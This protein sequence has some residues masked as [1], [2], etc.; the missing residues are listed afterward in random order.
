MAGD[1]DLRTLD[2]SG[3]C[4]T[5]KALQP[6][7]IIVSTA[8]GAESWIVRQGSAS[9]VSQVSHASLYIGAGHV[10]AANSNGVVTKTLDA[11]FADATL[12]VALRHRN[13]TPGAA[14]GVICFAAANLGKKYDYTG[15]I[16]AGLANN[17]RIYIFGLLG[18]LAS[19]AARHRLFSSGNKFYCSEIVL[20]AYLR[21]GVPITDGPTDTSTPENIVEAYLS[22][23]IDYVGHL[24]DPVSDPPAKYENS[25]YFKGHVMRPL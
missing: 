22:Q 4:I 1:I 14:C 25:Y 9:H 8:T 20:D 24:V 12:A 17:K 5:E 10:I 6:A 15:A 19:L 3:R 18:Y 7:D 23:R 21:A 2:G 16:G 11:A 13:M